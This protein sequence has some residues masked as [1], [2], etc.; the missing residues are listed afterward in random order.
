MRGCFRAEASLTITGQA[1]MG[2]LT[3]HIEESVATGR[4][5]YKQSR[6]CR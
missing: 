1:D 2:Y 3:F 4:C 6:L 5:V